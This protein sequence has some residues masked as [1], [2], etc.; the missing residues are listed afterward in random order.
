MITVRV[1]ERPRE[2]TPRLGLMDLKAEVKPDADLVIYNGF[3]VAENIPLKDG[4]RVVFIKRGEVPSREELE[5]LMMSRHTP[6][7]HEKVKRGRVG[8]AGLGGLG[9]QIA[10]ALARVGVGTLVLADY[11]VV[12]PSNLNRQQYFVDQIGMVK[13]EALRQSLVRINPYV[14]LITHRVVLDPENI[15][16]IFADVDIVV[17][18]FDRADMKAMLINRVSQLYPDKYIVGASGLAGYEDSNTI[19]TTRFSSRIYIVGD[20]QTAARPG[21]GLMA[22][23]VGIAAHHQANLVLRILLG[24]EG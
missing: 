20:Q 5:V 8:I 3:P 17:E 16:P 14:T 4:D 2:V 6:G 11:D 22:P 19:Q 24:E 1:N 21:M 13:V 7:V 12:E 10:F 9:S 23:R 18:A 15:G